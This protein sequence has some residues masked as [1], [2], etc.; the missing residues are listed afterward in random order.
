MPGSLGC[1]ERPKFPF[2]CL[3][4][5]SPT[6]ARPEE[7]HYCRCQKTA[8][9]DLPAAQRWSLIS[10]AAAS[11]NVDLPLIRSRSVKQGLLCCT[12]L[13]L[14]RTV[15]FRINRPLC[16][17]SSGVAIEAKMRS[18]CLLKSSFKKAIKQRKTGSLPGRG[19]PSQVLDLA[20][21]ELILTKTTGNHR[22][23]ANTENRPCDSCFFVLW[24]VET[25]P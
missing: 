7:S 21:N 22:C 6:Q 4:L 8:K 23:S 14:S 18:I 20:G 15:Y 13:P 10:S 5:V 2:P 12:L 16:S 17:C 19:S 3:V 11:Q 9:T 25:D 24:D 1:C